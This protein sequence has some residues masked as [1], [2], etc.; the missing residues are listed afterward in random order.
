VRLLALLLSVLF[1]NGPY[2]DRGYLVPGLISQE[3][4]RTPAPRLTIGSATFYSPGLMEA[5]APYRGLSLDG[6]VDGVSLMSPTDIGQTVWIWRPGDGLAWE[7]PFLNLDCSMRAD[8]YTTVIHIGEVV[9]V[10][11]ETAERWGMARHIAESPHYVADEWRLDDVMVYIGERPPD[12]HYAMPVDYAAW[13]LRL[14]EGEI[15]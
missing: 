12:L 9:E 8:M 11:F 15:P 2:W 3:A 5:Q 7:G 6:F 1:W 4:W 13:F 14:L 10:G